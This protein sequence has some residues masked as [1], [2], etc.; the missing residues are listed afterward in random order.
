[1]IVIK[2]L[3]SDMATVPEEVPP[4][5]VQ[6]AYLIPRKTNQFLCHLLQIKKLE[7][8]VCLKEFVWPEIYPG[9]LEKEGGLELVEKIH[10][11]CLKK[12]HFYLNL[13]EQRYGP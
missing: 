13:A 8:G 1:M 5:L 2:F 7:F 10:S 9:D 3:Y 12:Q 4:D 6:K 11:I